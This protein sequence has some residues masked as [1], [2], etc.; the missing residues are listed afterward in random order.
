VSQAIIEGRSSEGLL[1]PSSNDLVRN[2]IFL[3][4]FANVG[5]Y[6]KNL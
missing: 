4:V 5:G 2:N 1:L 3:K 6:N